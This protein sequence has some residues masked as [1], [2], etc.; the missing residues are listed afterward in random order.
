[1][2]EALM[3]FEIGYLWLSEYFQGYAF[4]L[5]TFFWPQKQ[6]NFLTKKMG[7]LV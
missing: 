6:K 7:H 3:N 4:D 1:M 2:F 5:N